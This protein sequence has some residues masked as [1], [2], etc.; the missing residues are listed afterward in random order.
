MV[1]K[2][3][4]ARDPPRLQLGASTRLASWANSPVIAVWLIVAERPYGRIYINNASHNLPLGGSRLPSLRPA[5]KN[6][7]PPAWPPSEPKPLA[8]SRVGRLHPAL[9][10][11][12]PSLVGSR[13]LALVMHGHLRRRN[14]LR[15]DETLHGGHVFSPS[16]MERP[17]GIDP[18]YPRWQRDAL[19]LSYGRDMVGDGMSRTPRRIGT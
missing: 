18:A 15:D 8:E 3:R 16:R 10:V 13:P 14:A 19:P 7:I 2:S 1:P 9:I 5:M 6:D 12:A 4:S 17:A 11:G